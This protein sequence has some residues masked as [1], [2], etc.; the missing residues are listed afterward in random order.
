MIF[1]KRCLLSSILLISSCQSTENLNTINDTVS[2]LNRQKRCTVSIEQLT[3]HLVFQ[4]ID[5][6]SNENGEVSYCIWFF[7]S[8]SNGSDTCCLN[9]DYNNEAH[10]IVDYYKS[11]P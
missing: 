7:P 4:R 9:I 3:S 10:C 11:C 8:V 5:T 2:Y 1:W 6:F